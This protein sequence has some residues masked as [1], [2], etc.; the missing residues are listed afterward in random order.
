MMMDGIGPTYPEA[1]VI[2]TSPQTAPTAIPT[3]DG[4]FFLTQSVSI[5]LTAAPAAAKFATTSAFT[6]RS[7][8]LRALPALKPNHPNHS[9]EAPRITY[10]ML[11]GR[12]SKRSM[13]WRRPMTRAAATA[14]TPAAVWTTKPPAKSMT[15]RDLRKPPIP[16]FQW[17]I[18]TYTN[19]VQRAM[20][21][22]SALNRIRSAKAPM[23]KAGVIAANFS[24]NAK[25]RSSGIVSEYPRFGAI[26]TLFSPKSSRL[27]M[28]ALK[29]GPRASVYPHRAQTRLTT[30]KM[31]KHW[32]IAET[33]FFLRTNPP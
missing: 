1:G 16:Q 2:A 32:A 23:I 7:F 31:A 29:G 22:R 15:P 19:V 17:A 4:F 28:N 20:K 26:P 3:A 6:P 18:G 13:P 30:A 33:R 5:Q 10:G 25:Y 12:L 21:I 27:P 9:T 8:A 11:F 14:E 24:W